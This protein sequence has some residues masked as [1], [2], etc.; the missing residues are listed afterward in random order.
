MMGDASKYIRR[1]NTRNDD[2]AYVSCVSRLALSVMNPELPH[3]R[4]APSR[5]L[6]RRSPCGGPIL[7]G[8]RTGVDEAPAQNGVGVEG[9][10]KRV[11]LTN[12]VGNGP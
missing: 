4:S 9:M 11:R 10:R 7:A 3:G 1:A 2:D 12:V 5:C 6:A 8:G